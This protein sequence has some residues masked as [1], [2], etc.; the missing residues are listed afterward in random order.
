LQ[1]ILKERV[2]TKILKCQAGKAGVERPVGFIYVVGGI[3][4]LKVIC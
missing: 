4:A 2:F 1:S 3:Q